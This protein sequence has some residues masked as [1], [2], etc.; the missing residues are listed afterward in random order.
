M[1]LLGVYPIISYHKHAKK[2]AGCRQ[3]MTNQRFDMV[4]FQ[5]DKLIKGGV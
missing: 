2:S 1:N 3:K 4:S 5:G